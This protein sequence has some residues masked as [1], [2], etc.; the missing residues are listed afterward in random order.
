MKRPQNL[1]YLFGL[2][3]LS[4]AVILAIYSLGAVPDANA[5][6]CR[7]ADFYLESGILSAEAPTCS[8]ATSLLSQQLHA[9]RCPNGFCDSQVIITTPCNIN[10]ANGQYW[11]AGKLRYKCLMCLFEP[12]F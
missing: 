3:P 11:V 12:P 7:C 10:P 6:T 5:A 2:I 4:A 8:E 1:R 9:G